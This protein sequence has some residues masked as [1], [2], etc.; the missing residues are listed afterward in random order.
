M[1]AQ[2]AKMSSFQPQERGTEH[3]HQMDR[4]QRAACLG[5]PAGRPYTSLILWV[6]KA[7]HVPVPGYQHAAPYD[8]IFEFGLTCGIYQFLVCTS[9]ELIFMAEANVLGKKV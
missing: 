5:D 8:P 2:K 3:C 7:H 6:T 4:L 1:S 9:I